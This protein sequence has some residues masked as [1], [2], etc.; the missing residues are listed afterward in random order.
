MWNIRVTG[1]IRRHSWSMS[2]FCDIDK[3]CN[4]SRENGQGP[5]FWVSDLLFPAFLCS[6]SKPE[7]PCET[8]ALLLPACLV[9]SGYSLSICPPPASL[10]LIPFSSVR[11]IKYVHSV[12]L[13]LESCSRVKVIFIKIF[14]PAYYFHKHQLRLAH[15]HFYKYF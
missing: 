7:F 13:S 15:V 6:C 11:S 14:I 10:T 9:P 8:A 5:L 3:P 4:H 2:A 1:D 12:S